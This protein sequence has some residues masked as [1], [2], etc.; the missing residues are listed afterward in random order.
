MFAKFFSCATALVL[1][2]SVNSARAELLLLDTFN[3]VEMSSYYVDYG[4]NQELSSR[5]SGT[6]ANTSYNKSGEFSDQPQVY[7]S[8]DR[9]QTLSF[10][11]DNNKTNWVS[12]IQ[13]F[14]I[15]SPT[16]VSVTIRP[17]I[18]DEPANAEDNWATVG[19]LCDSITPNDNVV[20][21]A[22]NVGVS[23]YVRSN[24]EW[25]SFQNGVYDA[26]DSVAASDT[27]DMVM[28]VGDGVWT[29]WINGEEIFS[30]TALVGGAATRSVNYVTLAATGNAVSSY[31]TTT[32][33]NL[34][35]SNLVIPEPSMLA[36]LATG[37][38]GLLCYAW[39]KR[40]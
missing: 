5:Q 12:L 16:T 26:G 21:L 4:L 22:T 14:G 10:Y 36:L 25:K 11:N 20:P 35:V 7:V 30:S 27:Y 18:Q 3:N 24:G 28:T 29:A 1:V 6:Y 13:D 34:Q 19:M 33:D 15:A 31:R 8:D 38:I 17:I 23:L 39:R 40:K 2:A 9:G 32:F 37:L